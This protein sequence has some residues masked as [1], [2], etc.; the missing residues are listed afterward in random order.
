MKKIFI[1]VFVVCIPVVRVMAQKFPMGIFDAQTEI[2]KAKKGSCN[3]NMQ[4]Q[5]YIITGSGTNIW[6][7]HDQFQFLYN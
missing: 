2:G 3:Y 5:E 1:I 4:T 6:A 7:T